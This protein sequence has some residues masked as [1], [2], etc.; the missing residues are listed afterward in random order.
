M[1]SRSIITHA[2]SRENSPGETFI[3]SEQLCTAAELCPRG[4]ERVRR[5]NSLHGVFISALLPELQLQRTAFW[6]GFFHV[7]IL[8][9]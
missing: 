6:G 2:K 3:S 1:L 5:E 4:T 8:S 9:F 7:I